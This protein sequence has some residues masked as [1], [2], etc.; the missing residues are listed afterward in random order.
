MFKFSM[1]VVAIS[2]TVSGVVHADTEYGWKAI[3][4]LNVSSATKF[5]AHQLNAEIFNVSIRSSYN[6]LVLAHDMVAELGY[7]KTYVIDFFY[8]DMFASCNIFFRYNDDRFFIGDCY[9][10][11]LRLYE[12]IA[13]LAADQ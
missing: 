9:N 3:D 8:S 11:G 2:L 13:S 12:P 1:L 6:P 7:Q 4:S 10:A 5:L